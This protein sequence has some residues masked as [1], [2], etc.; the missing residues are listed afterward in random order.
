MKTIVAATVLLAV[1]TGAALAQGGPFAARPD[2]EAA[3][4]G[5]YGFAPFD[6]AWWFRRQAEELYLQRSHDNRRPSR[7]HR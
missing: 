6:G 4:A 5:P 7:S 3:V 2:D 1:T